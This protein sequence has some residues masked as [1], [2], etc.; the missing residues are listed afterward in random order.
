MATTTTTPDQHVDTVVVGGGQ[1]GLSVGHHLARL[2]QDFL[3]LDAAERVGDAWRRRWDSLRL[4]TPNHVNSLDGMAF[5]GDPDVFPTKD[6]MADYLAAY[7]DLFDLPVRSGVRVQAVSRGDDG[8]FVLDTTAGQWRAADVVVAMGNYQ[9]PRLPDFAAD[10]GD[11][12]VAL[13]S[14]HYRRSDQLQPGPVLVVGAANS[15]IEIAMELV[16]SREVVVAGNHPGHIPFDVEKPRNRWLVTLVLRG[17]YHRVLSVD[18]PIGRRARPKLLHR[19]AGLVRTTPA[20]VEAAGIERVG[21]VEGVQDGQPFLA[22]GRRLD[23]ANVV[24]ATGHQSGLPRW[25]DLDVFDE[26]GDPRH[27]RGVSTDEP[28]LFFVGLHFQRSLSS[29]QVHGV[30]RDARFVAKR[31]AARSASRRPRRAVPA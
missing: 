23:V 24:W 2:G 12:V 20:E 3:I 6:E 14:S 16:E 30:G 8:R 18:T 17:I 22:D 29:G 15:G 9:Q 19:A 21:R 1:A 28:G 10:L 31:V 7:A 13:H 5:P 11:D 26:V 27:D 25:I 4:F